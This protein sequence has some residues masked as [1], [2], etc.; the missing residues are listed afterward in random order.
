MRPFDGLQD[1]VRT[2]VPMAPHVWFRLGGHARF[3]AKPRS[4][5]ELL[6]ALRRARESSIACRILGGGSNVL[7]R[8][9]GVDALVIQLESPFFSDVKFESNVITVGT[10]VPLTA[11]ISQTARAGLAGLEALTGIPGTVGGA[12]RGNAGSRQGSIG[13]YVRRAT[14][15]DA[16]NEVHVRERDDITFADRSSNLDE[17]VLLSAEFELAPEDPEAVVRRMRR[18]WIIKKE[19]QPYGHQSSGC[20]FKNPAPDV[21]AGAL[22]DQAGMKGARCGGAEVSDRHANFIVAQPGAKSDDV[23]RLIDQ[24]QQR[25]WQQFGY[26]LELQ[27]QVW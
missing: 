12:L 11:L 24:I 14:V 18:I 5:D 8:D 2:D 7:V 22:I 1:F 20:I 25:V 9:E 16:A 19:S 10:A 23:L 3:F 27:I 26:D 17:P 4:L 13:Q 21:S 15:L 6:T